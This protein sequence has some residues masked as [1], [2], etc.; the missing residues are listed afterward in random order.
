[1]DPAMQYAPSF[2][3]KIKNTELR[4]GVT[5]DVLSVGVT[6]TCDRPD[7][8]TLT[9]RDRTSQPGRFAGGTRL[10]WMDS[11]LF[12]ELIEIEIQMGYVDNLGIKFKGLVSAISPSFPESGVPTLTVRGFSLYWRLQH[13]R[14]TKPF[15]AA[16]DS[17]IARESAEALKLKAQVDETTA[18]HPLLS[19]KNA[20]YASILT[21]RAQR[22][23]YELVVKGE[24]L[25]FQRP[26]YLTRPGPALTLEWGRDLRSFTPSLSMYDVVTEVEVR[27]AQTSTGGNKTPLVGKASAGQEQT[28]LG[29]QTGAQI[30]RQHGVNNHLLAEDH[31]ITDQQEAN[32]VALARLEAQ[33]MNF[34]SGHGSCIGTPQ[35]VARTVIELKGLGQRFS[36]PYY[37]TSAT[38]TIDAGGY[39]TDFEV[40]RNGR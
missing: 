10:E 8:F 27:G 2:V 33:G 21:Q 5:V 29:A 1:M 9:L 3:I 40:R 30:A 11:N 31:N 25:Y 7:S 23:G 24:T 37:V 19:P 38:H 18:Q 13:E 36:G 26:L 17:G 6:D 12:D 14:R 22:I 39:R 32:A 35:L 28:K 16:T 34:I 20:T 15:K 4:H